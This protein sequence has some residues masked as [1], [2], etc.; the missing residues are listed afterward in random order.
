MILKLTPEMI[1]AL[2]QQAG[3]IAMESDKENETVFLVRLED[4]ANLQK[5]VDQ[6]MVTKLQEAD[7]D[8]RAGKIEP[9]DVQDIQRRGRMRFDDNNR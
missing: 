8:I 5:Q 2:R 9:W 4:V 3:P 6:T 1:S 7:K